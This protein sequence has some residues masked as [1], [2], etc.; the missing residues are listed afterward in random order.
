MALTLE[1]PVELTEFTSDLMD[2]DG[3][4]TL[5]ETPQE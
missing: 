2:P 4:P 3:A 5:G 1:A